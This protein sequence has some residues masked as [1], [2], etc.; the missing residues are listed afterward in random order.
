MKSGN[1]EKSQ[2]Q[3]EKWR[4]E[5]LLFVDVSDAFY[6]LLETEQDL[7]VLK[8]IEFALNDRIQDL[9]SRQNIGK[10]R[11]SEVVTT[12]YQLYNLQAEIQLERNQELFGP[13]AGGIFNRP[14]RLTKSQNQICA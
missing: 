6:L 5:Q 4:A 12:E 13:A 1:F 2:R 7:S 8:T 9:K 10:S 11:V 3:K 14:G